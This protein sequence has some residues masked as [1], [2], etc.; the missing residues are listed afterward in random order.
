[1]VKFSQIFAIIFT[2]FFSLDLES[3]ELSLV[4]QETTQLDDSTFE[5]NEAEFDDFDDTLDIFE[6]DNEKW[7]FYYSSNLRNQQIQNG[8]DLSGGR[9]QIGQIFSL[10]H[11]IGL[12]LDFG[13]SHFSGPFERVNFSYG[14]NYEYEI[15]DNFSLGASYSK[16]NFANDSISSTA[17]TNSTISLFFDWIT[18]FGTFDFAYDRLQGDDLINYFSIN[19]LNP[20]KYSDF[21]FNPMISVSFASFSIEETRFRIV[22]TK[23]TLKNPR[24]AA[25]EK[26]T[27][28][29]RSFG[30]SSI[31]V[32]V[33]SSYR[34]YDNLS[35]AILPSLMYIPPIDDVESSLNFLFTFSISYNLDF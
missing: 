26:V 21:K 16:V 24:G 18:K 27:S 7:N 19:Y 32:G 1:M 4:T 23:R 12:S 13:T 22:R 3:K 28:T 14:L 30:L 35:L 20:I 5:I 10:T 34:I 11:D 31:D 6:E 29:S 2:L 33:K 17:G 25:L 8:L 15:N 9:A